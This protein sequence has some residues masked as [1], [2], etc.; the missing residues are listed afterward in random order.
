MLLLKYLNRE[1]IHTMLAVVIILLLVVISNMFVRYLSMAAGG[2]FSGMTVFKFIGVL[3]PKYVA[4][5]LPISFF[6]SI[7]MV[8]GKMFANNELMVMFSCGSSWMRLLRITLLPAVI[9]FVIECFLTLS[10]VPYMVKN[11]NILKQGAGQTSPI[12]FV[13]PGRIMSFDG[14]SQVIYVG[15]TNPKTDALNDI[16]IYHKQPG[17]NK[18]KPTIITAPVGYP[19]TSANGSQYL[20]LKDGHYYQGTPGSLD[21]QS[22]TFKEATQYI[23]GNY[24]RPEQVDL[25]SMPFTQL[26]KQ[27]T[28]EASAELQWRF[29]FP[30]AVFVT[31]LIALAVC[32]IN[33][34]YGKIIPAVLI[35]IVYFNLISVARGWV[36]NGEIPSWIGIWSVHIL[37]AGLAFF[38][39]RR[40]NGP[41]FKNDLK[42]IPHE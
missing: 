21:Y 42:V 26:L 38:F 36:S 27:T 32:R 14:G 12:D 34:R 6:F 33:P 7:L 5:L 17:Q 8:Y 19:K 39:I 18:S 20:V 16:F 30:L 29:S 24:I 13:Q 3:L 28:P 10:V 1:V 2:S 4:Y 23:K 22:G 25:E 15:K 37:F 41:I 11:F 9:I 31:M 40:M 35:F